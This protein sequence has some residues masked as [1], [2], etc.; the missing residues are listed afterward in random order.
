MLY[1]ISGKGRVGKDTSAAILKQLLINSGDSC[2]S[3]A[4]ADF[5]KEILSKCFNLTK[6]QLYGSKKEE[7]IEGLLRKTDT[8]LESDISWTPREL[9]QYIGT[10]VMRSID[11]ECWINVVK[12]FVFTHNNYDNIIITDAR[13][14]NELDWVVDYGGV[15]IHVRRQN[16]SFVGCKE[17]TSENSLDSNY[18]YG[19]Y[20][21]VNNDK[22]LIYLKETFQK[23]INKEI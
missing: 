9:L 16:S 3:I 23:I 19:K 8:Y 1:V 14:L 15:H 18:F 20:Y 17:H 13:F 10:D 5:L 6:E 7:P 2:I 12:N 11:P 22:D 21:I 4:Y